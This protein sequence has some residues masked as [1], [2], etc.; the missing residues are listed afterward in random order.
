MALK[1]QIIF[2]AALLTGFLCGCTDDFDEGGIARDPNH[3]LAV[4]FTAE[5]PDNGI[6]TRASD[7][8]TAFTEGD[9]IQ[10]SAVFKRGTVNDTLYTCLEYKA[11]EWKSGVTATPMVWPFDAESGVFTAY[12]IPSV[13][14]VLGVGTSTEPVLMETLTDETDPLTAQ[15]KSVD[16]GHAVELKFTHLCTRL[17]LQHVKTDYADKYWLT[18]PE[19]KKNNKEVELPN[20]YKLSLN[21]N[22]TLSFEFTTEGTSTTDNPVKIVRTKTGDEVVFYLAPGNYDKMKLNYSYYR[23]YLQFDASK[24]NTI[25]VIK[26]LEAHK[27][28][29]LDVSKLLGAVNI[30]KDPDWSDPDK[31]KPIQLGKD[32]IPPFLKAIEEGKDYWTTDKD[33]NKVDQILSV[34]NEV[35]TLLENVDF[36]NGNK[37]YSGS[38][39]QTRTFNGNRHYI[40]NLADALFD[41]IHGKVFDL[42]VRNANI[43]A[44]I[45]SE[46]T[47][48]TISLGALGKSNSG[49]IT[50]I[51]IEG[52]KISFSDSGTTNKTF[53]VGALLGESTGGKVSDIVLGGTIEVSASGTTNSHLALGG[54]VGQ[55][56]G[57]LSAV[58]FKD[59]TSSTPTLTVS[60]KMTG[61]GELYTGGLVGQS[62]GGSI[63]NTILT[64]TVNASDSEAINNYTGG[65]VG[66]MNGG[67]L[68]DCAIA[69]NCKGGSGHLLTG[70]K[71]TTDATDAQA[72]AGGFAGALGQAEI[73]ACR[74]FN[75][76]EGKNTADSSDGVRNAV[77]GAVGGLT[78]NDTAT[79][80]TGCKIWNDPATAEYIGWLVGVGATV[81]QGTFSNNSKP[82][83]STLNEFGTTITF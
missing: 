24:D 67:K 72:Y 61:D 79:K 81:P 69:G 33:G 57:Q 71:S 73:T 70:Q 83:G 40:L 76:V 66:N 52:I 41:D 7:G 18:S 31:D 62:S 82:D 2:A 1:K 12:Y 36:Q 32:E 56:S 14:G 58:S 9:V 44:A 75:T 45:S 21:A 6:M 80:I 27:S 43:T 51:H 42:G 19:H 28:Y 25:D 3:P 5:Y 50:N 55:N 8:K 10:V 59:D 38:I 29:I 13:N 17:I 77:G 39:P 64:V 68:T 47:N 46:T 34:S 48:S 15:S 30:E 16:Y 78:R 20:A 4:S 26:N 35:V 49:E 37:G 22:Q 60:N 65:I 53:N 54:I 63:S 23:P 74:A 11:G